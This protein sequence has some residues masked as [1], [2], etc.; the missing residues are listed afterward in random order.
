MGNS[1]PDFVEGYIYTFIAT[2][3]RPQ[4]IG[5]V[6]VRMWEVKRGGS[7]LGGWIVDAGWVIQVRFP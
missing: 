6:R 3:F 2:V 1:G 5:T 7:G 4:A